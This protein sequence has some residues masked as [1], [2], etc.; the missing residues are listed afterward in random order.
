M[1][2]STRS[3][4]I[5][6]RVCARSVPLE[7]LVQDAATKEDAALPD[8]VALSA[9]GANLHCDPKATIWGRISLSSYSAFTSPSLQ[10]SFPACSPCDVNADVIITLPA[11]F[12]PRSVGACLCR[13]TSSAADPTEP[14]PTLPQTTSED[15]RTN[16]KRSLDAAGF[17]PPSYGDANFSPKRARHS[18][19]SCAA[20]SPPSYPLAGPSGASTPLVAPIPKSCKPRTAHN[21]ARKKKHVTSLKNRAFEAAGQTP[22]DSAH[23]KLASASGSIP[24]TLDLPF[25]PSNKT[26][27]EALSANLGNEEEFDLVELL[28]EGW[29]YVEWDGR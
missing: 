16:R 6:S 7:K 9:T 3:G 26:G 10:T 23:A 5:Y 21:K 20:V 14:Q 18:N 8:A 17:D 1:Q 15:Q 22:P 11:G 24:R 2:A 27:Y 4:K 29:D 25:L 28:K 12:G 13:N 19:A